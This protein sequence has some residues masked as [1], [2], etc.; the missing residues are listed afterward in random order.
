MDL[1]NRQLPT[2]HL[3]AYSLASLCLQANTSVKDSRFVIRHKSNVMVDNMINM[4]LP[5]LRDV[6]I[7][8]ME[9]NMISIVYFIQART[10]F[11]DINIVYILLGAFFKTSYYIVHINNHYINKTGTNVSSIKSL[12]W[13]YCS[14]TRFI[15]HYLEPLS[16][17]GI[18]LQHIIRPLIYVI[19]PLT[20]VIRPLTHIIRSLT[21]VIRT[22]THIIRPLTYVIRTLDHII[23]TLTYVGITIGSVSK[24]LLQE[25]TAVRSNLE[26][27]YYMRFVSMFD[28]NTAKCDL[29][30]VYL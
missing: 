12:C 19:R 9:D 16:Y 22:L 29:K 25:C 6:D 27:I 2:G 20:Y 26:R 7:L 8:F 18:T 24:Y 14:H 11:I 21:C 23:R 13:N 17:T 5:T 30:G 10:C 1:R 3:L 28:I 4:L 15:V